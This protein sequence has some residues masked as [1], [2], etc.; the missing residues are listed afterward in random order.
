MGTSGAG[1]SGVWGGGQHSLPGLV[2]PPTTISWYMTHY[3]CACMCVHVCVH[4]CKHAELLAEMVLGAVS[5]N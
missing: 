3:M 1:C 2:E 5:E 4:E